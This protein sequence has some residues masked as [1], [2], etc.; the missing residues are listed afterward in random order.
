MTLENHLNPFSLNFLIYKMDAISGYTVNEFFFFYC[1]NVT[2]FL[3]VF[4]NSK[5]RS[6]MFWF[7]KQHIGNYY[8]SGIGST[9]G[10]TQINKSGILLSNLYSLVRKIV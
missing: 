2:I 4:I 6:V 5:V 3:I 7:N 9:P 8:V 1:Y 10:D